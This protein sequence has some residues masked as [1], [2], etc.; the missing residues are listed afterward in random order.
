MV[1]NSDL[2]LVT[3]DLEGHFHMRVQEKR[4]HQRERKIVDN[5]S[6]AT[7]AENCIVY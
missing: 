4:S 2:Q 7:I 1:L 5:F 3:G 6:N